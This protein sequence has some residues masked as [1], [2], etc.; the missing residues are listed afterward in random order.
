MEYTFEE[1]ADLLDEIAE[2]F[3]P[4]FFETL[5][6][7]IFLQEEEKLDPLVPNGDICFLGE[8]VRDEYIG[9]YINLYYGSFLSTAKNEAWTEENW[10]Q[11]LYKTLSHELT[12]HMEFRANTHSLDDKDE[13]D[14]LEYWKSFHPDD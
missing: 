11:E 6:G 3:P 5:N 9:C 14:F 12:H 7:G 2:Q 8:Y 4:V 13:E 10:K 1:V